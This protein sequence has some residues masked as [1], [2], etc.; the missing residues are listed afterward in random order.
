MRNGIED[1]ELLHVLAEKHPEEA[2]R[3]AQQAVPTFTDYVRNVKSF[4]KL[5][6]KLL[7]DNK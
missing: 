4:R 2:R 5:Q 6:A 1:Y 7:A 3:L